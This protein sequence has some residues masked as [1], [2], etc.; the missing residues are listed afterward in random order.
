MRLSKHTSGYTSRYLLLLVPLLLLVGQL[1]RTQFATSTAPEN[2]VVETSTGSSLT[3][4]QHGAI[5]GG[6]IANTSVEEIHLTRLDRRLNPRLWKMR[7]RSNRVQQIIKHLN[8]HSEF[9][10][11]ISAHGSSWFN[12]CQTEKGPDV[13]AEGCNVGSEKEYVQKVLKA[14]AAADKSLEMITV[15]AS[16]DYVLAGGPLARRLYRYFPWLKVVI[17]IRDPITRILSKIT[18]RLENGTV[19]YDCDPKRK[20]LGCIQEYMAPGL[21]DSNYSQPLE[22]WLITFPTEQIHVV[23]YEE[24]L[25]APDKVMFDL[26]YFIGA[27]V[28]ELVGKF[29]LKGLDVVETDFRRGQYM[30]LLRLIESDVESTLSLLHHHGLIGKK[31]WL[32]RWEAGWEKV[33]ANCNDVDICKVEAEVQPPLYCI[34]LDAL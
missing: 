3:N 16:T 2:D 33:L 11:S 30:K 20:I 24:L 4:Q 10:G 29:S 15:D 31:S 14:S 13:K 23:Q 18:R 8:Q 27:N 7:K 21:I 34:I 17:V 32:S 19:V 26:K 1:F 9:D 5:D 22:D 6:S 25:E 12:A 28:A